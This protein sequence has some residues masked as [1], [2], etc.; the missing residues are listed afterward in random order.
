VICDQKGF[1]TASGG[2]VAGG[3]AAEQQQ[4]TIDDAEQDA[5]HSQGKRVHSTAE[6]VKKR[7]ITLHE[8][9]SD[10]PKCT[11]QDYYNTDSKPVNRQKSTGTKVPVL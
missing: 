5:D 6:T 3:K 1:F 7:G 2:D 11:Y 8:K 4:P 10:L 9:N